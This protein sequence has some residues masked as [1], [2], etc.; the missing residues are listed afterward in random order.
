[1]ANWNHC[2]S[3]TYNARLS[4]FKIG[5]CRYV[6]KEILVLLNARRFFALS[7][8]TVASLSL[9]GCFTEE[10]DKRQTHEIQG[11]LYKIHADDPF[12]GRVTNYPISVLGLFSV[13]SCVID[14]KKGLPDG[15]M[16][17]SDNAGQLL[18]VGHFKAGKRDGEEEKFD[19]KTGKKVA[20]ANWKQGL[21]DGLQEQ[22]NPENGERILEVNYTAGKKDGRERAWDGQGQT[23]IADLEWEN[24]KQTGFDN[25]GPD[26]HT[27]LAG[28]YHGPQKTLG[29]DGGRFYISQEQNYE[30][31]ELHGTQKRIDARGNVTELS[32][33]EYGKL[34]SRTMDEY[35]SFSGQ[36]VHHVSRLAIK[37]DVNQYI[38]SDLSNDGQEQ[39]WDDEG[40]LLRELH[41]NKGRLISA[42]AY[43]WVNGKKVGQ[44]QGV[45]RGG[46][47]HQDD[48]VKHGQERIY[49]RNGELEAVLM[50]NAG[51][52]V[53]TVVNLP[54]DRRSQ[55]PGKMAMIDR[56]WGWGSP[57]DE[58]PDFG[59]P[60]RSGGGG[61]AID[62][63]T[64]V[65][66]PAPGQA[67]QASAPPA[68][69]P[70]LATEESNDLDTCVQR[71]VDAVHA[72][73]P[74]AL[75][76]ADMLEEFEQDCK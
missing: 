10:V 29:L 35:N 58:I 11:L 61:Y 33:F 9:T 43:T 37:E 27:Y 47:P 1:M 74:E 5:R 70:A 76:R 4:R 20:E 21:Q 55:Y 44:Y 28:K 36:H 32:E 53:S 41:W 42:T 23:L 75:I 48:V 52:V 73:D 69:S 46:Q 60:S 15:E 66:I 30:N 13:G 7:A 39:Y 3:L 62:H 12:T 67:V 17:C 34:R 14:F 8:M 65:D 40:H 68:S 72:E 25:R 59:E 51:V 6:D 50:W 24:G 26:Q 63:V 64:I 45:A 57:V 56:N 16:R 31:G 54:A 2:K 38:A 18:G 19:A 49:D 22:F 71:R